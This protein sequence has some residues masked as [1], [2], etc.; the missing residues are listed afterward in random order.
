MNIV[1]YMSLNND[2][3]SIEYYLQRYAIAQSILGINITVNAKRNIVG[4][5]YLHQAPLS[6]LKKLLAHLRAVYKP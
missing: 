2:P 1:V 3:D 4:K 6:K 5:G